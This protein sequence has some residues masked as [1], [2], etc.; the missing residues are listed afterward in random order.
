MAPPEVGDA[1]GSL[2]DTV[3]KNLDRRESVQNGQCSKFMPYLVNESSDNVRKVTTAQ[4]F[5]RGEVMKRL[6]APLMLLAL[7]AC[8]ATGSNKDSPPP[9]VKA[10][11]L[12][13]K[14]SLWKDADSIK[15]ASIQ[16]P[17]RGPSQYGMPSWQVC[18]R[19]NA[20]N[21]FGGYAGEKIAIIA[22]P[23]N[24]SGPELVGEPGNPLAIQMYCSDQPFVPFPELNGKS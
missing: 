9:D 14:H 10:I 3:S 1:A 11:I 18:L 4:L 24:G 5:P 12:A 23:D 6:I 16:A 19:S 21:S 20:R 22:I 7:G 15:N 2:V 13:N 17:H 8:A